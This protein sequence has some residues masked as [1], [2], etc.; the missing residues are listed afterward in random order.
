[1]VY[2]ERQ[3]ERLACIQ[4]FHSSVCGRLR[5]TV[6]RPGL[7]LVIQATSVKMQNRNPSTSLLYDCTQTS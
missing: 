7:L 5:S 1:M 6:P 3:H 4:P 2:S